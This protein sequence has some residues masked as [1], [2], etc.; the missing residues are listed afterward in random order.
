MAITTGADSNYS[1]P[2]YSGGKEADDDK[3]YDDIDPD[4]KPTLVPRTISR[5]S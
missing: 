3:V 1:M 4:R 5:V 2:V